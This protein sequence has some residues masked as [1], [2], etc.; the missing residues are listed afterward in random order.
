MIFPIMGIFHK[1]NMFINHFT[2]SFILDVL[3][4]YYYCHLLVEKNEFHGL[5][6]FPK[7]TA[8]K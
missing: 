3:V 2:L 7:V 5:T 4:R 6:S 1:T 8:I